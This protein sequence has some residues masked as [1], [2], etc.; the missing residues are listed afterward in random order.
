MAS[1]SK[2]ERAIS[3]AKRLKE[4]INV[5]EEAKNILDDVDSLVWSEDKRPLSLEEKIEL[6]RETKKIFSLKLLRERFGD[7]YIKA[8][9]NSGVIDVIDSIED[10]LKKRNK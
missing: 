2:E 10:A 4:A 9:D 5:K 3:Y 1:M 8:S 7:D 6:V